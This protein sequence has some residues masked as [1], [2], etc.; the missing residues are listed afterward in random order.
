MWLNVL[1]ML[2]KS[3]AEAKFTGMAATGIEAAV[4]SVLTWVVSNMGKTWEGLLEVEDGISHCWCWNA[5]SSKGRSSS[6]GQLR[7]R[8]PDGH[9]RA[10]R[11][12]SWLRR[13]SFP[14]HKALTPQSLLVRST[15]FFVYT[16]KEIVV[17]IP[18][19]FSNR[20]N[21]LQDMSNIF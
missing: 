2:P 7:V 6:A 3:S 9:W 21:K 20:K 16:L 17:Q 10:G 18:N 8:D 12:V 19:V 5:F 13:D 15:I 1:T 4:G 11:K 14:L